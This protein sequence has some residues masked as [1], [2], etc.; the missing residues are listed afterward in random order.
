M[1]LQRL[2]K[3]NATKMWQ[4]A[5]TLWFRFALGL[6]LS[7]YRR[8]DSTFFH[9]G[10][11]DLS[12][13]SNRLLIKKTG[14]WDYLSF[15]EIMLIRWSIIG[16]SLSTIY[17]YFFARHALIV[18]LIWLA[19]VIFLTLFLSLVFVIKFKGKLERKFKVKHRKISL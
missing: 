17:G 4:N 16:V 8:T 14:K 5:F 1:R 2:A 11:T 19:T 18:A 9:H 12:R 10:Q 15:F 3:R 13:G 7:G 6:P